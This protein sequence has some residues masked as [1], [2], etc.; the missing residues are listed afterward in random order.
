M[1]ARRP[2]TKSSPSCSPPPAPDCSTSTASAPQARPGCWSRSV[3]SPGSRTRPTSRPGTAPHPSTPPPAT[4]SDTGSPAEGTGRSTGSCTSWPASRSATPA[5]PRLLRAQEGRRQSTHGGHALRQTPTLRHRLPAD[6]QRHR[7]STRR[8]AR[9]GNRDTTLTPARPAHIPT[10]ALRT[11][12]FP[13]PSAPSLEHRY[14]RRLDTEG[15]QI[16]R[17]VAGPRAA[18]RLFRLRARGLRNSLAPSR[19][20]CA[21]DGGSRSLPNAPRRPTVAKRRR[22][23]GSSLLGTRSGLRRAS[24]PGT[25]SGHGRSRHLHVHLR[26][27]CCHRGWPRTRGLPL[28]TRRRHVE[29]APRLAAI[30]AQVHPPHA[31]ASD[32]T[33]FPAPVT[34][35][36]HRSGA[37][38]A[39]PPRPPGRATWTTVR[40]GGAHPTPSS[41]P[42]R[43]SLSRLRRARR[44]RRRVPRA[45]SRM[46]PRGRGWGC[47]L[48]QWAARRLVRVVT[49][50]RRPR[51]SRKFTL[52]WKSRKPLLTA[53]GP[54]PRRPSAIT[55]SPGPTA[56]TRP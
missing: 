24:R 38:V 39:T 47:P 16:R 20:G 17:S 6:A 31:G 49:L 18:V 41:G 35:V 11:S 52:R 40:P 15:S 51:R 26:P 21:A 9:E 22:S 43:R 44:S 13:D 27:R 36:A 45:G 4:R 56:S 8:R 2:P 54:P 19:S 29:Q 46:P 55:L 23:R 12:H 5:G 53:V 3:T 50:V 34:F 48:A 32:T 42:C 10:P 14:R 1:R 7:S 25:S 30:R 33:R 37:E 28:S